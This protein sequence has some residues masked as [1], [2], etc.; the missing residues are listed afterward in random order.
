MLNSEKKD[1]EIKEEKEMPKKK[2]SP[3]LTYFLVILILMFI[4][5]MVNPT[6]FRAFIDA[7]VSTISQFGQLILVL[8]VIALVA[9]I[10]KLLE[11]I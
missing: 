1:L 5:A 2:E 9:S 10:L 6:Q 4:F 7:L 11:K 3:F 8:L